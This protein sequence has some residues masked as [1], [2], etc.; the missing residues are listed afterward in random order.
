MVEAM[1]LEAAC[2]ALEETRLPLKSVAANT[3]YGD[4]QNLRRVFQRRLSIS[5]TQY[6]DRFSVHRDDV[7]EDV[8]SN[9]QIGASADRRA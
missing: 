3:G 5:P 4:E 9:G 6:R 8:T 2:R 7:P 1:R